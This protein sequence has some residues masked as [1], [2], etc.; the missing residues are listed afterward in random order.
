MPAPRC[1]RRAPWRQVLPLLRRK[2]P[3]S[4]PGGA[5]QA[6]GWPFCPALAQE[7]VGHRLRLPPP[8]L[9]VSPLPQ[10]GDLVGAGV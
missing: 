4:I 8:K 9:F 5:S 2:M 10:D 6:G 1:C 7:S 3:L